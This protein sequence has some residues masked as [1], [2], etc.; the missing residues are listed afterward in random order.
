MIDPLKRAACILED[1]P[2][3]AE[4][5]Y[6]LFVCARESRGALMESK[7][8]G[9]EEYIYSKTPHSSQQ[10]KLYKKRRTGSPV[11]S[12]TSQAELTV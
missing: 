3:L 9:V 5:L 2:E 1:H 4:T 11:R 12:V 7:L 6:D 8:D 10:R